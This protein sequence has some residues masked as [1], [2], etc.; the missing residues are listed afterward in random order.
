MA[1]VQN[2]QNLWNQHN[3]I[4]G[5]TN[6]Q[7][8][9][10]MN[11]KLEAQNDFDGDN[12]SMSSVLDSD[13]TQCNE[14]WNTFDTF[15][16]NDEQYYAYD[17]AELDIPVE[18]DGISLEEKRLR[19]LGNVRRKRKTK[20]LDQVISALRRRLINVILNLSV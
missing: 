19:P 20:R 16:V 11:I 9:S 17:G 13:L 2:I 18:N 15:N 7:Q 3:L 1:S 4:G 14:A 6:L 5:T 10:N 8:H 12:D